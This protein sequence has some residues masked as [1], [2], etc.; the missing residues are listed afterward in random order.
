[1]TDRKQAFNNAETIQA[2]RSF[3]RHLR[4]AL[5][6]SS[7]MILRVDRPKRIAADLHRPDGGLIYFAGNGSATTSRASVLVSL[8]QRQSSRWSC[9]RSAINQS[10]LVEDTACPNAL[11]FISLLGSAAAPPRPSAVAMPH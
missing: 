2:A 7:R 1:M 8:C 4:Q 9:P 3:A 5:R 11:I 10:L 6:H